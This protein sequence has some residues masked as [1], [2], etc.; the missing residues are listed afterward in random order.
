MKPNISEFSYG[1][2]VTSELQTTHFG[3]TAVPVFPSLIQE[4]Q[5][6]GGY[7]VM[8]STP[9]FLLFIQFKLSDYMKSRRAS[10]AQSSLLDCPF[11][12]MHLRPSRHSLQHQM[13]LDLNNSGNIVYYAAPAFH[14]PNEFN[15]FFLNRQVVMNS[16][17][18]PPSL[19]GPLPDAQ[20]HCVSFRLNERAF[21]CSDAVELQK[22]F[23]FET[24]VSGL[25]I[26]FD[27]QVGIGSDRL[28]YVRNVAAEI[29]GLRRRYAADQE[30]DRV[31]FGERVFANMHPLERLV[32]NARMAIDSHVFLVRRAGQ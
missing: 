15:D 22:E 24:F 20:D 3:F 31:L 32:I 6:G 13:L 25:R 7:D 28:E 14:Q 16:A 8:L 2:A 4:G 11:Y 1:Y 10:E 29:E 21:F 12:R 26:E 5:P 27:R 23:N 19:I 30:G 9:F 18:F 17:W